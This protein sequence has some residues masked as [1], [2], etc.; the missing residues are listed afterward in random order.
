MDQE[1]VQGDG[2]RR[3]SRVCGEHTVDRIELGDPRAHP[4]VEPQALGADQ[5]LRQGCGEA[6]EYADGQPLRRTRQKD[7]PEPYEPG[8]HGLLR[9]A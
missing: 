5:M 4:L 3:G 7:T 1:V 9:G 2:A 6:H 8:R